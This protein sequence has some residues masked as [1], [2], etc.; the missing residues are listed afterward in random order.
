MARRAPMFDL[1]QPGGL[2][3]AD[4]LHEAIGEG[5]A[6]LVSRSPGAVQQFLSGQIGAV[7]SGATVGDMLRAG[8]EDHRKVLITYTRKYDGKTEDY[9][10][11]PY[12]VKVHPTTGNDVLYA[13]EDSPTGHG[14]QQIHSF[15]YDR[16]QSAADLPNRFAPVWQ[17]KPDTV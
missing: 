16:I 4:L 2:S 13:T 15:L 3:F 9:V 11:R 12:E 10:V 14:P 6:A 7:T 5:E 17:T 8:M 1:P